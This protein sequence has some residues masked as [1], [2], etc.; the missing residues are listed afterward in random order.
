MSELDRQRAIR[1]KL[2]RAGGAPPAALPTGFPSLDS[3]LGIGGLP[4]GRIVEVFGPPSC[5]KT[6]LALR[7]AARA[8]ADGATVAW[9]D[10]DRAFDARYAASSGVILDTLIL[11]RPGH[12]EEALEIARRLAA[13][14]AVDLMIVDSAAALVPRLELE[15]QIGQS[16]PGLQAR[17]V[18]SG[19]RMLAAAAARSGCAALFLNQTR[20]RS[21]Y[22]GAAASAGGP[23]LKMYAA[24]RIA[25]L[26]CGSETCFRIL[27]NKTAAA[28]VEG[29]LDW[30][31]GRDS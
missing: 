29:R 18:G 20:S 24:V 12:A 10:A 22:G 8:Q 1:A 5:G 30:S 11:A 13:S 21:E 9:I 28:F 31:E 6:T 15:S 23:A 4:R 25:L 2:S 27:K 14:G 3:A 19:L 26:P 17:V 7:V 16:G